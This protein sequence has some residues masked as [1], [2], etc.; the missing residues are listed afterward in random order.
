MKTTMRPL[1]TLDG[2]RTACIGCIFNNIRCQDC[3]S[4]S[5]LL[6]RMGKIAVSRSFIPLRVVLSEEVICT[7]FDKYICHNCFQL[8]YLN[9]WNKAIRIVIQRPTHNIVAIDALCIASATKTSNP[10]SY[11]P[12]PLHFVNYVNGCLQTFAEELYSLD[13]CNGVRGFLSS[14]N[15]IKRVKKIIPCEFRQHMLPDAIGS[16]MV[17]LFD[18]SALDALDEGNIGYHN[19]VH[20][21]IAEIEVRLYL[22]NVAELRS[23]LVSDEAFEDLSVGKFINEMMIIVEHK[24]NMIAN[25]LRNIRSASA[26]KSLSQAFKKNKCPYNNYYV[27]QLFYEINCTHHDKLLQLYESLSTQSR[28]RVPRLKGRPAACCLCD[29]ATQFKSN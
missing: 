8:S 19:Y 4:T 29:I 28:I 1:V 2:N 20:L 7:P 24:V 17:K 13:Y 10:I 15:N 16:V 26:R 9:G 23:H 11:T 22:G 6:Y 12:D 27:T 21:S 14:M 5:P 25:Q 3:G 18:M